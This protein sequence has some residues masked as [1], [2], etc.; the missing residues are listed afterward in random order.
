MFSPQAERSYLLNVVSAVVENQLQISWLYSGD[1]HQQRTI[2]S[3]AH[4]YITYLR[5]LIQHCQSPEAGGYTPADFPDA[6]LSQDELDNL[7]SEL[8]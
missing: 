2:E 3:L 7:L 8:E 1:I 4:N 5:K 6:D